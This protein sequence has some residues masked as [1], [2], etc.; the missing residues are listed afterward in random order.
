MRGDKWISSFLNPREMK[1]RL[2]GGAAIAALAFG[3][4]DAVAQETP[5]DAAQSRA[6]DAAGGEIVVTARRRDER[7]SD[8][9]ASAAAL[10]ADYLQ[11]RGGPRSAKDALAGQAGV[12]FFDTTSPVNSEVSIRG[13]S[14]ARATNADPSVGLYRNG[15]Y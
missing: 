5:E 8:V 7:L 10:T 15:A 1:C 13:S 11:E 2:A 4:Q 12:R 6:S 3:T 9:P 14:T